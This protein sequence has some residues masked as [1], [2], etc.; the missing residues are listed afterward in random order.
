[1]RDFPEIQWLR[2]RAASAGDIGL[3]P[4]WGTNIIPCGA[5]KGVEGGNPLQGLECAGLGSAPGAFCVW[6]LSPDIVS[7]GVTCV[8][9]CWCL[10]PLHTRVIAPLSGLHCVYLLPT[11]GH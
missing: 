9:V 1:M 10:T 11:H 3:T 2:R 7:S 4:G 6:L 5:T 8:A